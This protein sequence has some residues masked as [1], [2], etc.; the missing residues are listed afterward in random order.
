M[1]L[2]ARALLVDLVI[3][4]IHS[5]ARVQRSVLACFP[6]R[7]ACVACLAG[8]TPNN[9][10]ALAIASRGHPCR[11]SVP[12]HE[13]A[14]PTPATRST[15]H[16]ST[17]VP[18][19]TGGPIGHAPGQMTETGGEEEGRNAK[20]QPARRRSLAAPSQQPRHVAPVS[21]RS[22]DCDVR[23]SRACPCIWRCTASPSRRAWHPAE[24]R[25]S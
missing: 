15:S 3:P 17:C 19:A 22:T 12:A 4:F 13:R 23:A 21:K 8:P 5:L 16:P 7:G 1:G 6:S 10:D 18:T 25:R 20:R 14:P 2:R 9:S 24:S 11:P